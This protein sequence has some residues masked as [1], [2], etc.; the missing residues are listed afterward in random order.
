MK[1]RN[2]AVLS[3]GILL[4][5]ANVVFAC[6]AAPPDVAWI[7]SSEGNVELKRENKSGLVTVVKAGEREKPLWSVRVP[8]FSSLFSRLYVSD[9]G[10]HIL[11]VRGNHQVSKLSDP[12]VFVLKQDGTKTVL[13][14]GYFIDALVKTPAPRSSISP[15]FLWLDSVGGMSDYVFS[16]VNAKGERKVVLI[17]DLEQKA[18]GVE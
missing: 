3:V 6:W 12:A 2:I 16:I 5:A 9:T 7:A 11:H 14:A 18:D 10:A 17:R 4:G 13:G 1:S 15:A 8:G